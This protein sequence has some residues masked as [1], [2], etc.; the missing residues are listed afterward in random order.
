MP[1]PKIDGLDYE[2]VR[3][4][5]EIF[6]RYCWLPDA[7]TVKSFGTSAVFPTVRAGNG[8][9]RL[10]AEDGIMFD[11]NTT[12]RW[13][14]AWTH[15]LK[16]KGEGWMICHVWDKSDSSTYTHLANLALVREC[17]GSLTDKNGPLVN[18]LRYHA[19]VHYNWR[20]DG[21]SIEK[22]VYY[23]EIKWNY[24]PKNESDGRKLIEENLIKKEC[25]R[26]SILRDL[27]FGW[28]QATTESNSLN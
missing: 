21:K 7:N 4:L 3:T 1:Y 10:T 18:Y 27:E 20:P 28:K 25:N 14:L 15:G 9:K 11:D 16:G 2:S 23:D 19:A 17:F 26:R 6:A 24:L 5:I 22:P 12:P 8:K 13:A